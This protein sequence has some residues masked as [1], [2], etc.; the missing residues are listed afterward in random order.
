[1]RKHRLLG[2]SQRN[3]RMRS[4][5]VRLQEGKQSAGSCCRG[6]SA[7][8]HRRRCL[9]ERRA[10]SIEHYLTGNGIPSERITAE[11]RGETEECASYQGCGGLRSE[12]V[13][14]CL[15]PDRRVEVTVTAKTQQ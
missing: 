4:E 15:Q 9:S 7:Q 11:G 14:A 3:A 5:S 1:M 10:E 12:K 2:A 8:L 6:S 13:I